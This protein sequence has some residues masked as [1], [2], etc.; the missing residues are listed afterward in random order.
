[1]KIQAYKATSLKEAARL[2]SRAAADPGGAVLLIVGQNQVVIQNEGSYLPGMK[3]TWLASDY[4]G[5]RLKPMTSFVTGPQP[6]LNEDELARLLR[7]R[8]WENPPVFEA[9]IQ[10]R[11]PVA[12]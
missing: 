5:K 4:D 8:E 3:R 1:V 6:R 11:S 2:L 7:R 12:Q 10:L 9:E